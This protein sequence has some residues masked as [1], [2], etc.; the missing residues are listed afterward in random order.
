MKSFKIIISLILCLLVGFSFSACDN[1]DNTEE[2]TTVDADFEKIEN[3]EIPVVKEEVTEEKIVDYEEKE[4]ANSQIGVIV[5]SIIKIMSIG[6]R[7]GSL[8]V[9]V[10]NISS[11]DIQYA[12]LSVVCD[13][14]TYAFELSTLTAG[15]TAILTCDGAKFNEKGQYHSWRLSDEIIFTDPLSLH[16]DVFE[17]SGADG[18]V[19]VKNISKK[20]IDGPIHVYYKTVM[21][22]VFTEGT[23]YRITIDSLKK[24]EEIQVLSAHYKKDASLVMFVTYAE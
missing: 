6:E 24:N 14:N 13:D 3:I 8:S 17:I 22:G 7:N 5:N 20:N 10:R 4:P 19:S 1:G 11:S 12:V 21:D 23:T 18:Y 2:N 16:S 9:L 15:S